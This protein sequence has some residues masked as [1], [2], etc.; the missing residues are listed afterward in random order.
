MARL[1]PYLIRG[2]YEWI[3]D[4]DMTPYILVDAEQENVEVPWEYVEEGI[5]ICQAWPPKLA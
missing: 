3:V 5:K 2:T 4:H 1:R